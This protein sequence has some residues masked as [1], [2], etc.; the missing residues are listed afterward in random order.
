MWERGWPLLASLRPGGW[1]LR[2]TFAAEG[3]GLQP[4][5]ACLIAVLWG[6]SGLLPERAAAMLTAAGYENVLALPA[7]P[8]VAIRLIVGRRLSRGPA[9]GA[10]IRDALIRGAR[11]RV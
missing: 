4:A 3:D 8:G 9:Q 7:M 5:V 11:A 2:C 10:G 1:G 6:S